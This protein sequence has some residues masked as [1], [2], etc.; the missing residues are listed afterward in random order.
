MRIDGGGAFRILMDDGDA[1]NHATQSISNLLISNG[2]TVSDGGGIQSF[3]NLTLDGVLISD[4]YALNDGGGLGF[5]DELNA[6]GDLIITNSLITNNFAVD[7]G[8]GIDFY[9]GRSVSITDSQLSQ[10]TIGRPDDPNVAGGKLG[11]GARFIDGMGCI[12]ADRHSN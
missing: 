9:N 3:E 2:F 6:A 12:R 8:G 7:D 1:S 10:N 4:N 5:G 11:G